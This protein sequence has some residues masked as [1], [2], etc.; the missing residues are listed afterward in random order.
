HRY[1]TARALQLE[2]EK[3][4]EQEGLHVKRREVGEFISKLFGDI[5]AE[6]TVHIESQLSELANSDT[7]TP[8]GYELIQQELRRVSMSPRAEFTG[9][10]TQ[11]SA[12]TQGGVPKALVGLAIALAAG[13]GVLGYMVLNKE[14]AASAVP[15]AA[16]PI[17]EAPPTIGVPGVLKANL[18]LKVEP[19]DAQIEL[20]GRPLPVG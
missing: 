15:T 2:L 11:A 18:R 16:S 7:I 20:D 9:T 14:N 17:A 1:P 19:A 6:L 10:G 13:V 4:V 3:Y 5:R 8:S 12:Q